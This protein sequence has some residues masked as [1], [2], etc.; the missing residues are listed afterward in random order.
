MGGTG[1]NQQRFLCGAG[2][3]LPTIFSPFW[4]LDCKGGCKSFEVGLISCNFLSIK[5]PLKFKGNHFEGI[6]PKCLF[7]TLV[8]QF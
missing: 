8:N 7:M 4:I 2:I 6:L 5:S 1:K 3:M